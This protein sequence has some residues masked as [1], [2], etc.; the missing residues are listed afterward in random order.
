M[1]VAF[2]PGEIVIFDDEAVVVKYGAGA[3][4]EGVPS[5]HVILNPVV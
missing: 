5:A 3:G 4:G 2:C 1:D